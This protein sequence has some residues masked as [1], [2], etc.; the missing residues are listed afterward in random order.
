[1]PSA[2]DMDMETAVVVKGWTEIEALRT[3]ACPGCSG[4]WGLMNE[5]SSAWGSNWMRI[6]VKLRAMDSVVGGYG[7][8]WDERAEVIDG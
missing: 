8:I 3:V 2:A 6:E 4:S 7:W 5:D 1:V